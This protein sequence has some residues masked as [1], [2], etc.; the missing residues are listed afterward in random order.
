MRRKKLF[1]FGAVTF[2]LEENPFWKGFGVRESKLLK[3]DTQSCLPLKKGA[4]STKCIQM[5]LIAKLQGDIAQ[6]QCGM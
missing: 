3:L 1:L 4:K 5:P 6:P 2:L